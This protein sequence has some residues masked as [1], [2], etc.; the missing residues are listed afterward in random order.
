[1]SSIVGHGPPEVRVA[2]LRAMLRWKRA[3]L[4]RSDVGLPARRGS[5]GPLTQEDLAEVT[6]YA[7]TLVA[8]LEN[9]ALKAPGAA[10]LND[11]ASALRMT[12]DERRTLWLLAAGT[13]PSS[14]TYSVGVDP[15]LERLVDVVYPHPAYL[16]DAAWNVLAY[17]RAV[18]EWFCDFSRMPAPDR[19]IAKWIFCYPHSRHVFVNWE[20]DFAG[21][22]LARMRA[23]MA[24][25]PNNDQLTGLVAELRE[26]SPVAARLW[27]AESG[28]YV[29]PPTEIRVFRRPGHTDPGQADD[30]RHHVAMETVILA[31]MRPGDERRCV[32]FFLP[33][34]E[35]H[36]PGIRS[37]Q[38]C[39]ACRTPPSTGGDG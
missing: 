3:R 4:T 1:M 9:G 13:A 10:F 37:E 26:R 34:G 32:V 15:G 33:A 12:S 21:V 8:R 36:R 38:A 39:R 7:T 2:L 11:I 24:R 5:R 18:E 23:V 31:P 28:V 29:D 19:N 27:D 30:H 17:N 35:A 6:G 22:F 25:F 14:P 20:T 16:T